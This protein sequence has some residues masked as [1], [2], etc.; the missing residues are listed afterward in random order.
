MH[1][2]FDFIF[3]NIKKSIKNTTPKWLVDREFNREETLYY[4]KI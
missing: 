1:M 3:F 2:V 4:E